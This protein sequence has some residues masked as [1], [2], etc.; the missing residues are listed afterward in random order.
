MDIS[1]SNAPT[2]SKAGP[3]KRNRVPL[4]C[5]SCRV[6]KLRCD[7][8][9]PCHN[10]VMRESSNLCLY[11]AR[12]SRRQ[13]V[14]SPAPQSESK[15]TSP[16][17]G[18]LFDGLFYRS[19][20]HWDSVLS[21]L[22]T[23]SIQDDLHKDTSNHPQGTAPGL[24]DELLA[25]MPSRPAADRLISAFFAPHSFVGPTRCKFLMLRNTARLTKT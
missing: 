15:A 5:A 21:E 7:R 24:N 25:V 3:A 17:R 18:R 20:S 19:G 4:S 2:A 22:A 6:R 14:T 11:A 1:S 16:V 23:L 8:H 9:Q 10:C 12:P 13:K